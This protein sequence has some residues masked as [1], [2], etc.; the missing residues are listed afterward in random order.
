MIF[1]VVLCGGVWIK[2]CVVVLCVCDCVENNGGNVLAGNR[3]KIDTG[4]SRQY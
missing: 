2:V 3:Y 1:F 4:S